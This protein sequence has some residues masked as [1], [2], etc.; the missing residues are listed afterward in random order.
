MKQICINCALLSGEIT[1]IERYVY[2]NIKGIDYLAE[3]NNDNIV[4]LYAKGTTP[5]FPKLNY[6]KTIPLEANG[7]KI[8][9]SAI[10]RY[11]KHNNA[12]Y[13]SL[14]GGICFS[15]NSVMC[16][17][18]IRT[19]IYKEFDP[20]RFRLKCNINVLSS[21][22][23]ASQMVTISQTAKK[24]IIHYLKI[25]DKDIDVIYPGW[26]HI[27]DIHPD[28]NI[29]NKIK[30]VQKGNYYYSLS[31]RAPHKN[32]KWVLEIAKRNPKE[33]FLIGG[34]RW[35]NNDSD[36]SNLPNLVY[37]GYIT[38][39]ENVA[40][41]KNC[42]AFLHP[43]KY[44]GFG[45]TPLEALACG[46]PICVSRSSCLPEIFDDCAHYFDPDDYD[47]NLLELLNEPVNSPD[48]LLNYYS[49]KKSAEQWYNL[50]EEKMRGK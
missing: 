26:E 4:L 44:E 19:W 39:E 47:V 41:M 42:K 35:I 20:I 24:E 5:K 49:W 30:K 22:F 23:L 6:L 16:T 45:I 40:L 29:F 31:S 18:D 10:R 28:N 1:G 27:N 21:K 8:R 2:E 37:L 15:K 36:E 12:F 43:S 11:M 7:N 25:S 3:K 38:D 32:F 34:K 13:F 33:L 48:K 14:H 9:I 17:C 46:V 50:M